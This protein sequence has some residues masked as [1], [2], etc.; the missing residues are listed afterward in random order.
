MIG[1]PPAVVVMQPSVTVGLD[2][3]G[4]TG[5]LSTLRSVMSMGCS[6]SHPRSGD[7]GAA[8]TAVV[9][10]D[11][12]SVASPIVVPIRKVGAGLSLSDAGMTM[13]NVFPEMKACAAVGALF[14]T[15]PWRVSLANGPPQPWD[16]S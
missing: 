7:P 14:M 2:G 16:G 8:S 3:S 9:S 15:S 10:G 13:T 1:G 11:M 6:V 5:A 4:P 12:E